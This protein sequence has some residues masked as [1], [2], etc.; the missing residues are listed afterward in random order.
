MKH[1][2]VGRK[3][4]VCMRCCPLTV[5]KQS[6]TGESSKRRG[7]TTQKTQSHQTTLLSCFSYTGISLA[8]DLFRN[9][10]SSF[11][12]PCGTTHH[13][14]WNWQTASQFFSTKY[15]KGAHQIAL[16]SVELRSLLNQKSQDTT[17]SRT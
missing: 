10:K 4:H 9:G 5:F 17:V 3:E 11:L 1:K 2:G 6:R 8:G 7:T 15:E 12:S 13:L 16:C 14:F